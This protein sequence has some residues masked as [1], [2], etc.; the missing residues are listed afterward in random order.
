MLGATDPLQAEPW[1]IRG[2]YA[3]KKEE[4]M[5]HASDSI[6][7]AERELALWFQ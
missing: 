2:M 7:S 3:I 5:V 1:T 6:A 4:N